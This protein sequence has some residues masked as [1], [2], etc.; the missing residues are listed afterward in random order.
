MSKRQSSIRLAVVISAIAVILTFVLGSNWPGLLTSA[1]KNAQMESS[2]LL[3][4]GAPVLIDRSSNLDP[5]P[6]FDAKGKQILSPTGESAAPPSAN[7]INAGT[8]AFTSSTGNALEDMSSGTTLLLAADTDDASSVVSSIGFEFWFDGVRQTLF[9][10]NANGLIRLGPAAVANTGTN[11]LADTTVQPSIAPY[12][13]DLWVGNNGKVHYKIVGSAPNRKLVIEWQNEQIPRVATATAGAGTFQLWMYETSGKIEFVYGSGVAVTTNGYSVGFASSATSFASVTTSGPTVAYG[14]ANNAQTNAITS[15]TKYTFT[16]NTPNAPSLNSRG[17][18][19]KPFDL[20][21]ARQ[22]HKSGMG[23]VPEVLTFTAIGLNTMT[24]NWADNSTNEVGY[25]VYRS[26]DGTNYDFVTQTAADATSSVQTGLASNTTYFWRVAAVTEGAIS[27]TLSASQATTTGT[28]VGTKTVGPTGNYASLTAANTDIATNGLAGNVTLELQAA[29][30]STVETFPLVI[31]M[32]GSPSSTITIRP[33]TGASAL[34]LAGLAATQTVDLS[35]STNVTIDGRAGGAGGSQLTISN[36][37]TTGVALRLINGAS[38]NTVKFVSIQGVN[39]SATSGVVLFST[40]TGVTGNNNNTIDNCNVGDGATT[41]T[42]G[43]ASIGT[44]STALLNTGNTVSNSNIFNFHSATVAATGILVTTNTNISNTGWTIT[45]NRIFQTASRASTAAVTHRGILILGGFDYAV[46]GNTVGFAAA[47]GTGTYTMTSS[48]ATGFVG[49]QLQ[50]GIN[51]TPCSIQNNTVAGISHGT[52]SG[53]LTAISVTSGNV[54]VGTVTGNT[55]GSGTGT[56][57]IAQTSTLSGAFIVGM[58][59]SGTALGT[60]VMSNNTIGSLMSTGSPATINPNI[61]VVQILGGA[62]TFTNNLIGSNATANSVQTTTAGTSATAQQLIVMLTGTTMP[63]LISGNTIANITNSGTGTAHV[64]RGIQVQSPGISATATAGKATISLNTVHDLTGANASTSPIAVSGIFITTGTGGAPFGGVIDRNTV[65]TL[66]NINAGAVSTGVNG[67]GLSGNSTTIGVTGGVVSNNKV[68]DLRNA[69]TGVSAIAP[70]NAN[71]IFVQTATTFAEVSNNMVSLGNAQT[72]NTQFMGI[73]NN[74]PMVGTL[75]TYYNSVNITGTASAG[76]LP[77]YGFLRGDNTAASAI[78]APMDIK[79]NIFNNARTGG[80]G[81]HYAIGNVNT[82]PATGWGASASNNNVLN[83]A[84]AG[85]VGIWGLAA[86]QTFAGWKAI[87][88]GD[89]GSLSGVSVPFV[90][91]AT[92]DL[93]VNFGVTPTAIE[94]GGT[95]VSVTTDFDS[96]VRPGPAGSVN[97]GA[98]A[99][100]IGADEFDGVPL[101]ISAPAISYTPLAGTTSTANRVLSTTITDAT[102][103]ASGANLPRIYF[104]KSTDASYVST[105]CVMTGGTAQ[106]GTYDCTINY[107]LVGGGSVTTGDIVQYYVIAQDTTG[108]VGSN[109][110]GAVA[111]NVNTVTTPPTPNSYTIVVTY[112]GAGNPSKTV[113]ASGCDFDSLTNAG[114]IFATLNGAVLGGNFV[115]NITGDLIAETG[116]NAL[117]QQ[118]EEGAGAGTFTITIVP[119]GGARAISGSSANGLITLNAA[120]RVTIDGSTSGGTDRSLTI[121]NTNTGT[122]SAVVWLQSNGA[123]GAT[124]NTIKNVNIAGSGAIQTLIGVGSGNNAISI[125]STGTSNNSNTYQNNN[126]SKTQYGIY[127]GGLSAV[128]KNTG[129]VVTQ[130]LMNTVS[131]NNIG[132]GG[133]FAKFEDGIQ[134]NRNTISEISFGAAF[135]PSVF[136]IALGVAPNNTFTVFTGSDVTN[137]VVSK[138]VI[139][140]VAQ[141]GTGSAYGI[142]INAVTS[143]TTLVTNNMISGV[144]SNTTP[145]DTTTGILVG[146]GTGSTTQIYHNSVSMTGSRGAATSPSYGIAINSGDPAVNIR[147]NIFYNTQTTTGVSKAYAIA[148]GSTTFANMIS[149]HNDF[150]VTAGAGFFIGQT[151]GIGTSGTDRLTLADWQTATGQDTTFAPDSIST[152]PLFTSTTDLHL[153]S[154]SSPAFDT[155]VAGTGV[156]DDIDGETR[157]SGAAPDMGADEIQVTADLSITKTDGVTTATPGGSVTYTITASNAGPS[158]VTGATVAD[159]FPASLTVSWSC[160]GAGGGT[161]TAGGSGNINDSVNLPAGAS[162]TYTATCT[163]SAGATGSLANTATVAVPAGVTDPTPGNNSATD[164]DALTPSANLGITKTDG[165]TTA[166]PGG[167]VTYTITASNAGPSNTTATVADTFPASLTATWTC[168]GAGGGTCTAAG[169]GN[170]NDSVTLPAGGSVTYTASCNISA[171]ATGTLVNTATVAGAASD[172][173]PANN[174]STDS[175]TLSPSANLGIT[176]TDG[177]TTATPG[178]SVTYTIVASNAG[179]S[180]APGSTVADTFPA[181]LTATWTCVGAGG[182]TC[183]A[184]GSGNIN[185]IVNLPSGGSVTYTVSANISAS[186]TG[187][188]SNTATVAAAGGVT[189]PVPGN[190]SSTDSD[191]LSPSANLGITKTDGVTTVTAGGSLTYTITASNAGPSN[192]PGSTVADTLPATLTGT[193]TCVGSGGGTCTAAGSGNINDTVNLPSGGS[194]TYTVSCAISGAASGSISNTATVA[195]AGGV[196]DPTPGNNSAT[197]TD[198]VSGGGPVGP[199]TVTA[200]AGTPGPTDYATLQLA[201]DAIN[202]G[203][204]QG[205]ITVSIVA[206]TT[207]VAAVVLNSS[208]AGSASYTSINIRPVNDGV[209]IAGPTV[210]GRGLIELNGADNVTIDGDNPNTAGI[211]RNLT[212]TNT[213]ANTVTFTSVIRIA[214]AATIVNSADNDTIKNLNLIG[215]A[216]GRNITGATGAGTENNVFGIVAT[217]G[218]STVS[219]TTAPTALASATATVGAGA[220]ATNLTISNNSIVTVARA[221]GAQGAATT[222]FPGLTISNNTIGN[223]TAGAVD[224]VYSQGVTASGSANGVI[225]G[226]TIWIEGF[227]EASASTHA[228][229]VGL[230]SANTTG[231][232]VERNVVARTE[233]NSPATWPAYGINLGGGNNHVIRNNFVRGIST[234]QVAGTGAFST[235]FGSFGIRVGSGTGHKVYHNSVHLVGAIGGTTNT[236]LTAAFGIVATGQTGCDVRDNIFSNQLTG[237]NPTGTRHVAI[238]LPSGATVAM[239]LTLNNN[240]Y[241]EG[242]DPNSRMAQTGTTFGT[243]EFTAANFDPTQTTPATNFRSYTSTLSAAGTNDNASKKVDPLFVSATDLHLTSISPMVNTGVNVG[244]TNDID[245]ETRDALPDIGA[246]EFGGA[247]PIPNDVAATAIVTPAPGGSVSTGSTVA[248]QASFTNVGTATQTNVGVRFTITGPG[249]FNY[250]DNQVI[251]SISSGQTIVVTFATTPTIT[252]A[253]AYVTTALVTTADGNAANDQVTSGFTAL[254]PLSGTYTVGTAG[255]FTSLTNPGGIFSAINGAGATSNLTI[256]VTSDLTAETGAIALNQIA[257]G[258]TVLLQPSGGAARTISGTNATG[259]I[260][261]NGADGVTINGLN[262][263]GNSLLI[264]TTGA[265]AAIRMVADASNNTVQNCTVEGGSGTAVILVGTGTTTGNDNVAITNN[266]IRDRSDAAGVPLT[267]VQ[268]AGTSAAVANSGLNISNNAL[269]NFTANGVLVSAGTENLTVN[270][271]DVSQTANR[272]TALFGISVST[273]TGIS[274]ISQNTVHGL[275]SSFAGGTFVNTAGIFVLDVSNVTVSRNRLYDFPALAGATGRIVGIE[276]EGGSGTAST[277]TVANNMVSIVTSVATAQ[278]VFGIFDFAFPTN[279]FNGFYNTV[280]LGGTASGAA[281]SWGMLRGFD[282]TTHTLRN[283]IAF[284]NRTGGTGN[285]F[286][287]GDQSAGSG[288]YSSN[289]NFFAGTGATPANFMDRDTTLTGASTPVSFATWQAGPPAR[290]ANSIAGIASTVNPALFFVNTATGDLHLLATAT[291]VMDAGTPLGT[292]TTDFDNDPRS[293]T[294]PDIGADEFTAAGTP[295]SIQFSAPTYTIG[296]AGVQASITVT[297]TGGTTGAVGASYATVAGGTATG[298]GACGGTVDY[299]TTSGT[300]SFANGDATPQSFNIPLC[301]DTADEPDETVNLAL[302]NP[303]G[304]ATLGAQSTAILTIT[305]DD[306]APSIS[307]TDV[308]QAEGN[309]GSSSFTFNVNLSA[310]SG[311]TVTV[312]YQTADGT[313]TV[314][315]ND[316]VAIPDTVLTF[317]PGVSTMQVNVTVNGDVTPEP[318]ETFFVNLSTAVNA[319]ISDNQGQGTITNDD[320][321]GPSMTISD[322]RITEGN[323]GDKNMTF[324]VTFAGGGAASAHYHTVNGTAQA[325]DA[326]IASERPAVFRDYVPEQNGIVSFGTNP[327]PEGGAQTRTFNIIIHGD[328]LKEPNEFFSVVLD[329]PIGATITDPLGYGVIV[330]EDR[331]Y[332]ADIDHD[333]KTD[334]TVFRPSDRNW[335][336]LSSQTGNPIYLNFGLSTD[337]PVPGDYDGDAVM[338]YAMRRPGAQNTWYVQFSHDFSLHAYG[339][340]IDSDQSVQADYDGDNK[341]DVA[342]FRNGAWYILRSSDNQVQTVF[343]G[344]AGDIAVPGDFDGDGK[345]DFTVFR[346]GTWY[347]MR[348]S[349]GSTVSQ[350]WGSA[351]DKPVAGDFDGDGRFDYAVFR[352]GTWYILGSLNGNLVTEFWGQA[353]D[354]PVVGDYDGDGTSDVA[355]FRPSVGVWYILRSSNRTILGVAWGMNGD[356]PIPAAYQP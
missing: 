88:G 239:N 241:F 129:T 344:Q 175:D 155:G 268:S 85:T 78:T 356:I 184:A 152:D 315:N 259:L 26:L 71:G 290:D 342:V 262:T 201:V 135:N 139:G 7:L 295:G 17:S 110:A 121:T 1:Q 339:W 235:T 279:T 104:K 191:T 123:N 318:N 22:Q 126:I 269:L 343:F 261:L 216:T 106:N 322:A 11:S 285:H 166:T 112:G 185:D 10:A 196:T 237:G 162:V 209:T 202:N 188:L 105:Q 161:C 186:A 156:T 293:A 256:N 224:Q 313:A 77:S 226:N 288:T 130:N 42:N 63:M 236:L 306:T 287:A 134:I 346:S 164:T 210:T 84:T 177:V 21:G 297:R 351:G 264:R 327:N 24:L 116:A 32:L 284:N 31:N 206:N 333:Q 73:W 260:N 138:N 258:F 50:P 335:Y 36:T 107:A 149:N 14:T 341:T 301:N 57:S 319:T 39:T 271:N 30:V 52:T 286:A 143:G 243:G 350:P 47:N 225:S 48:A 165:V 254:A 324:T 76:A 159:T 44:A 255:D 40:S 118:V 12:W 54:N 302:T 253:G 296:E 330:D 20:A 64:I 153:A 114:G 171:S 181:S 274:T 332:V 308:T 158:G 234:D 307:I 311:Q 291:Q 46:T 131:P 99:P 282:P 56:G 328:T 115:I 179:P 9:S 273:G 348:S 189:D 178:G 187:T 23:F 283:N 329:T 272:A 176:K 94:S 70:P 68:Y 238:F 51:V 69:S 89:A 87:S 81:K 61:N 192:A 263:G 66:S 157:P 218:G 13:D 90:N 140:T 289:Y 233:N 267:L 33:E 62:P 96:Q 133:V 154:A 242:T 325:D 309:V 59:A 3:K 248:P 160:V 55:V 72:T 317:N 58:N 82:V 97:G 352:N 294:T 223:P 190:N 79:N 103:V 326:P 109:P 37:S 35:G 147:N 208:G 247:P 100:D 214:L 91:A 292:V 41:P 102:G 336:T 144:V 163:I 122:S 227:N 221:I 127:S 101:D 276:F 299:V 25:A 60:V 281:N 230:L 86:D 303:T 304:G 222:V 211:N 19:P 349:N 67:I 266:T 5:D 146:G 137:A 232:T 142:S 83:S 148:N 212:I 136:G 15:G 92:A 119:S 251:P 265:G 219:Q 93:H 278:S 246:D 174:S 173:A 75:R 65:F 169:S 43:I 120:D 8:Y 217:S 229:D 194:V 45:N 128:A 113:C 228:I 168:V 257:G 204:H 28:V 250:L 353:G 275:R 108:N 197:D 215:S 167:S 198:T 117:N 2:D 49:I 6:I 345:A 314:A 151:G 172:P 323:S 132:K 150:F 252:T 337:K 300:V 53:A 195:T 98:T 182:G 80:T 298:G 29:Y 18:E 312:H 334:I 111:T 16:P 240:D 4:D 338:D 321:A 199:V 277:A 213:A 280:Y 305:D 141:T 220:T 205:A 125:T 27:G 340:G 203:T 124:N 38:R 355:V 183:T 207:E 245:G 249:G 244:V 310:A 145:S 231:I 354:I 200:T 95:A 34:A 316:Y 331:A 193:W 320:A 74:F 270:G 180:N 170:I 347:T